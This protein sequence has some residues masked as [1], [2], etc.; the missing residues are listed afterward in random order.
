MGASPSQPL[1]TAQLRSLFARIDERGAGRVDSA[2]LA[3]ALERA[4]RVAPD[5]PLVASLVREVDRDADG[6]LSPEEFIE[7][8]RRHA[9]GWPALARRDD[10]DARLLLA[11]GGLEAFD[12]ADVAAERGGAAARARRARSAGLEVAACRGDARAAGVGVGWRVV[13][14]AGEASGGR[15]RAIR[16]LPS[17]SLGFVA[18]P[19]SR[20]GARATAAIAPLARA[21]ARA[22]PRLT[23]PGGSNASRARAPARLAEIAG[24]HVGARVRGARRRAPAAVARRIQAAAGRRRGRGRARRREPRGARRHRRA[25]AGRGVVLHAL[26]RSRRAL[27]APGAAARFIAL[28]SWD[29]SSEPLSTTD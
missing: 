22:R 3:A 11:K 8:A 2:A 27:R 4:L 23:R 28:V 20:R 13:E 6:A 19:R 15:R 21:R 29:T 10:A 9:D 17:L 26:R 25:A 16:A 7:L 12:V 18:S 1:S 24:R 14:L 5:E